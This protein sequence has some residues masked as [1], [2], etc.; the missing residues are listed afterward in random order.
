MCEAEPRDKGS[1]QQGRGSSCG[2]SGQLRE[3]VSSVA[4]DRAPGTQ[5]P[6]VLVG[7]LHPEFSQT[8]AA[9]SPQVPKPSSP[10]EE[11]KSQEQGTNP[12][13]LLPVLPLLGP[14]LRRGPR[15]HAADQAN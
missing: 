2:G 12:L 7:E 11:L 4:K 1:F 10:S 3:K 13:T 14:R 5:P 15:K 8:P 6:S 9:V